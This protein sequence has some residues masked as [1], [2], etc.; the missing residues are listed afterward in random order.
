MLNRPR[1]I[2]PLSDFGFKFLFGSAANKEL[3]ISL[4]NSI[5]RGK[6]NIKDL[7]FNKTEFVGE[8]EQ[9]GAVVF[10]LSC[11]G[12]ND[13]KFVIEV[14]STS[15]VN[16]KKRMLY[17]GCKL[18]TDQAPKGRRQHWN[19]AISEVYIIALLA[20]FSISNSNNVGDWLNYIRLFNSDSCS[21]FDEDFVF[22]YIEL[23][24]FTKGVEA[25]END[26]DRWMYILKHLPYLTDQPINTQGSVFE[27]LFN[28]AEYS[29]LN[30]EE[31]EMYD[32]SLKRLWDQEVVRQYYE[33]KMEEA[34]Q[35]GI[36]K[37]VEKGREEA[38]EAAQRETKSNLLN[39]ARNMKKAG[40]SIDFIVE[41][42]K[43]SIDEVTSL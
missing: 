20:N 27:K 6:K 13:E 34:L 21:V 25:L 14:Q 1:Y 10:D 5:F 28:I 33:Q 23:V 36:E 9:L 30:M 2:D 3:L 19:Y 24:N 32:V 11:I 4:L 12:S 31:K 42:T 7:V 35:N 15:H 26:L 43:L 38:L 40:S 39:I 29:K 22:I 37:G 17:Y 18:I 8:T 16:F 41:I